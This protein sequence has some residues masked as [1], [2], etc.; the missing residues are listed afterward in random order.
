MRK[1]VVNAKTGQLKIA[2]LMRK[3]QEQR[4]AEE[5]AAR[6]ATPNRINHGLLLEARE[7]AFEAER[8]LILQNG[9]TDEAKAYRQLKKELGL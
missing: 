3:E 5:A 6:A 9:Q 4:L 8:E 1:A 7:K 2:D